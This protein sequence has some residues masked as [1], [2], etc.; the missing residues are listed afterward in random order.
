MKIGFDNDKYLS[1]QSEHIKE[2]IA[3]FKGKLLTTITPAACCQ[4]F[5][6]TPNC[7]CS[8]RLATR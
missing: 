7:V 4:V 8:A 1:I 5:S 2:R 3:K 6:P